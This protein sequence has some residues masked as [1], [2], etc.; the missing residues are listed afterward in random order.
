MT[1]LVISL[2]IILIIISTALYVIDR[3]LDASTDDSRNEVADALRAVDL[4]EFN[5]RF[6]AN[7]YDSEVR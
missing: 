1:A 5:H 3:H 7:P 4:A 2:S 6:H